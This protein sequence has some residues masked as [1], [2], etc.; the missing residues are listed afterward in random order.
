MTT[1]LLDKFPNLNASERE[2]LNILMDKNVYQGLIEATR[3][4]EQGK[5]V[6]AE[7]IYVTL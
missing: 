6:P 4:L 2:T 7:E 1:E 5:T 3:N